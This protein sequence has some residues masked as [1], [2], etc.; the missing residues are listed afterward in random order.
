M[1][2]PAIVE[3]AEQ[4]LFTDLD[5]M[6]AAGVPAATAN[7]IL[8]LREVYNYWLSFP[9]KKEREIV[10]RIISS[11]GV[12]KSQAYEDLGIVKILLG[13]L[14]KSTTDYHRYRFFEMINRAFAKAEA[15]GDTRSMVA[16]ADKYAK[17][18]RLDKEEESREELYSQIR[19]PVFKFTDNPEVIGIKRVPNIREKIKA[20]KEQYWNEDIEDVGYEDVDFEVE[21]YFPEHE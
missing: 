4:Y 14:N 15:A 13:N 1:P 10:Q 8:R 17:Y 3:A 7:R 9:N 2:L 12:S 18:A 19:V 16:A 21:K 6:T 20:K 5:K 11:A